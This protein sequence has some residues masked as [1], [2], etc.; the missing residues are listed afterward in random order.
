MKDDIITCRNIKPTNGIFRTNK[1]RWSILAKAAISR[2]YIGNSFTEIHYGDFSYSAFVA[3]NFA[4]CKRSTHNEIRRLSYPIVFNSVSRFGKLMLGGVSGA[5]G[6]DGSRASMFSRVSSIPSGKAC[7]EQGEASYDSAGQHE[8]KCRLGPDCRG[9]SSIR[10]L[11]L[12]AKIGLTVIFASFASSINLWWFIGVLERRRNFF[13]GIYY[14]ALSI[15]LFGFGGLLFWCRCA[16]CQPSESCKDNDPTASRHCSKNAAVKPPL[17]ILLLRLRSFSTTPMVA[18]FSANCAYVTPPA[19]QFAL[20]QVFRVGSNSIVDLSV[21][22]I[23]L[24]QVQTRHV[25]RLKIGRRFSSAGRREEQ[26]RPSPAFRPAPIRSPSPTRFRPPS[27]PPDPPAP[28]SRWPFP[29]CGRGSSWRRG[30]G[31]RPSRCGG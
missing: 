15:A 9:P 7:C 10:S 19:F 4:L 21:L 1:P 24:S 11:P 5:L 8:P 13:E 30:A 18:S 3:A 14:G 31:S 23:P 6:F 28:P 12:S 25:A 22:A 29:A 26:G 17:L 20:Q 2:F 16:K 27:A